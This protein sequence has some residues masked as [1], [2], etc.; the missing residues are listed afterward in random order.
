MTLED[1]NCL[2][3]SRA[4]AEF[5]RCCGSARWA[6][7]MTGARPFADV[8]AMIAHGDTIWTS[9]AQTDR[10]EAFAAHPQ[11]GD[12]RAVS[13]W[14]S[15][16]QT[17][18]R[19]AGARTK[20]KLAALNVDYQERFGYIFIVCA[21]DQSSEDILARLDARLSNDPRTELA[22]AAEEQ[23]KI[24]ALRLQKLVMGTHDQH[25]RS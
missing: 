5:R 18:I 20:A 23:R 21:T 9:L 2:E 10:L 12:Q 8:N 16:E 1:L 24:T 17:G 15:E 25:A 13:A 6:R 11:I 22:I 7:A 19:L 4:E 14:S 3:P